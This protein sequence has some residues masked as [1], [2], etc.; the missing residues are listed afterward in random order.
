MP[1]YPPA[2]PGV[3]MFD[4]RRFRR[5]QRTN[6]MLGVNRA[7]SAKVEA[8]ERSRA[9]LLRMVNALPGSV[10][11]AKKKPSFIDRLGWM[12]PVFLRKR[13]G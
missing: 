1:D 2:P 8:L 5:R 7:L 6:A 9:G 3:K 12:L 4:P 10:A 11:P 13:V